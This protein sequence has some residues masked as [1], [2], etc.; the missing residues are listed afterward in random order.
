MLHSITKTNTGNEQDLPD[1][2][3]YDAMLQEQ[4]MKE[5]PIYVSEKLRD[6]VESVSTLIFTSNRL[7]Q[8]LIVWFQMNYFKDQYHNH[9]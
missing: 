8:S 6:I 1:W 7:V 9:F 3:G 4:M 5:N 2:S